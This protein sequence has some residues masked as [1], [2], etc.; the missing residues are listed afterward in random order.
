MLQYFGILTVSPLT[1]NR[2]MMP[3]SH[4]PKT[5]FGQPFALDAAFSSNFDFPL[6][7]VANL[8]KMS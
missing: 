1:P 2:F 7:C 6:V 5:L 4:I 3:P 8:G